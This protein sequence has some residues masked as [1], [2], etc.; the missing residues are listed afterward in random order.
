MINYCSSQNGCIS[1]MHV[2]LVVV[3]TLASQSVARAPSKGPR[4]SSYS[5]LNPSSS[6]L[7]LF[8]GREVLISL[9]GLWLHVVVFTGLVPAPPRLAWPPQWQ[10]LPRWRIC[11][12]KLRPSTFL[13][14]QFLSL[15]SKATKLVK[16]SEEIPRIEICAP[17]GRSLLVILW[18][19]GR[20]L[21]RLKHG[22]RRTGSVLLKER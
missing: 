8:I 22:S 16:R 9:N 19:C 5:G 17:Q 11:S 12:H 10:S 7:V 4:P 1:R 15:L 20:P 13:L 21:G 2:D 3:C 14:H 6:V 18:A